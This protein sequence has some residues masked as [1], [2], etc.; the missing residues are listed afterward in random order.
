MRIGR[1]VLSLLVLLTSGLLFA[2][3][4]PRAQADPTNQVVYDAVTGPGPLRAVGQSTRVATTSSDVVLGAKLSSPTPIVADQA[5]FA[6][7]RA[8]DTAGY[9]TGYTTSYTIDSTERTFTASRRFPVG[10]YTF[11]FAYHVDGQWL[12]TARRAFVVTDGGTSAVPLD[13]IDAAEQSPVLTGIGADVRTAYAGVPVRFAATLS[14]PSPLAVDQAVVAIRDATGANH[15]LL[16]SGAPITVIGPNTSVAA[17]DSFFPGTYTYWFAYHDASG[18]HDLATP[19]T[20]VVIDPPAVPAPPNAS[21]SK[22][23]GASDEFATYD[24]AKWRKSTGYPASTND[25]TGTSL[26]FKDTNVTVSGGVAQ[27]AAKKESYDG[28][29]YTAGVLE[30]NFDVP[31]QGSYVEVRAKVLDKRANVLSAIWLQS[32]PTSAA[33]N[34]NPEIDIQETFD[35]SKLVSTEHT[36]S[37][38]PEGEDHQVL[39]DN[40]SPTGVADTSAGYHVYGLERRDGWLRFYFDGRLMWQSRPAVTQM[41]SMPRHLILSLEA[42]LGQPVDSYLPST[43]SIDWVRTYTYN[44]S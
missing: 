3:A 27:L 44:G 22:V 29:P 40:R 35:Y 33:S 10:S 2:P 13:P 21:W 26:A 34:P 32:F 11:W 20:F 24:P 41:A 42:H 25:T 19:R 7:R 12:E 28:S 9:D 17:T 18:W 23:A 31:G 43:F 16:P 30:S 37:Y 38:S 1:W 8:G 6:V 5:V 39:D 4:V 36:W 15:D 14:S